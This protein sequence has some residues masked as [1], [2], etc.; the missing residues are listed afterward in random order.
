[1]PPVRASGVHALNI[2]EIVSLG[3]VIAEIGVMEP[4]LAVALSQALV[5]GGLRVLEINLQTP[6]AVA[7]I[8]AIR[9]A[10]PEAIL[11]VGALTKAA[12]FAAAGRVGA[13]FGVTPGL[14]PELA[15]AAR[16]ARFPVMAGVMTPTDVLAAQH[17]G[18]KV[19][20]LF[21]AELAGGTRMLQTLG[22]VFPELEF[23]AA[24]GISRQSAPGFL[25]LPNVLSVGGSWMAPASLLDAADWSRVQAL[26][27]EAAS[28]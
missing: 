12:D 9:K 10:V 21:P 20:K 4:A 26:A 3:P 2:R 13:H 11:G 6:T 16:G 14:T 23:H 1:M 7:C 22:S 25:A 18:F 27:R 19:L 28:L 8:D 17:A 5:S 24:G 15:A